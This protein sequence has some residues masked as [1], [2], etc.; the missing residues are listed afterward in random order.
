MKRKMVILGIGGKETAVN[1]G[2][3]QQDIWND[4]STNF[5]GGMFEDIDLLI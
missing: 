1:Y 5:F 2:T 4:L 3:R